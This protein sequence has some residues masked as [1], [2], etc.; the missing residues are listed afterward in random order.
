MLRV[1]NKNAVESSLNILDVMEAVEKAYLLNSKKQVTL[2]PT[3]VHFFP[4]D[5]G[6]MDIKSGCVDSEGLIGMKLITYME[7]NS[8]KAL[9][10]LNGCL[11]LFE[12]ATGLP[13]AL[14]D[15]SSVTNLRTGAAAGVGAKYLARR[16]SETALL[17]GCGGQSAA[18]AAALLIACP[19]I[20]RLLCCCRSVEKASVFAAGLAH[21]LEERYLAAIPADHVGRTAAEKAFAGVEIT[22]VATEEGARQADIIVT[23][24]S[25]RTPVIKREWLKA[26]THLCCMG[27]DM[28]GKQEVEESVVADAR[29]FCDDLAK[30]ATLGEVKTAINNGVIRPEQLAGELGQVIAGELAGRTDNRQLTLFDSSGISAQDILTAALLLTKPNIEKGQPVDF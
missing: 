8:T 3:V 5:E 16:D 27:A 12:R 19:G 23:V 10:P 15:A 17:V 21:T 13:L 2:F 25:S 24:T 30:A 20:K 28:E 29:V 7:G 18:C 14:V 9:P 4:G 22:G 1:F 6:D 11:M 26:G